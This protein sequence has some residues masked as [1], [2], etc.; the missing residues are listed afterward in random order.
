MAQAR[1][2]ERQAAA[3]GTVS[4]S[5]LCRRWVRAGGLA[6]HRGVS[7]RS[8]AQMHCPPATPGALSSP[9]RQ[10]TGAGPKRLRNRLARQATP[11]TAV[12]GMLLLQNTY[13]V[14]GIRLGMLLGTFA[15]TR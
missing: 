9:W 11:A 1:N 7:Q 8:S 4:K 2:S 10:A 15:C 12:R 3:K 13:I 14:V 6:V 5:V